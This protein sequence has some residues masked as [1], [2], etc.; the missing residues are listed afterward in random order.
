[1]MTLKIYSDSELDQGLKSNLEKFYN[2]ERVEGDPP[3]TGLIY[4]GG[5]LFYSSSERGEIAF[6]FNQ[7]WASHSNKNYH[8]NKEPLAKALGI[9][10]NADSHIW[11]ITCGSGKDAILLLK[12]GAKVTGF[13]RNPSVAALLLSAAMNFN[14]SSLTIYPGEA[15]QHCELLNTSTPSA[16][17]YDPMY[18][19]EG[20]KKSALP[21]K[22]MQVFRELVGKDLDEEEVYQWAKQSGVKRFVVKRGV[23]SPTL[24]AKPS[25]QYIGKS[26]RYDLYIF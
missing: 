22:E 1:M 14:S 23:K 4:R 16:I 7:L 24:R 15:K 13:E 19:E 3:L 25:A 6:D 8:L 5:K 18:P 20:K 26:A 11:D 2:V 21:R 17:Y 12:F 10:P 9:K